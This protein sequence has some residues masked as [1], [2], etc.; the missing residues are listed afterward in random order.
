MLCLCLQYVLRIQSKNGA[1]VVHPMYVES[2]EGIESFL[3]MMRNIGGPRLLPRR[4]HYKKTASCKND[5]D[6]GELEEGG[7]ADDAG[8]K[9][10]ES[11]TV[12]SS[13]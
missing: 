11:E 9:K 2:E 1:F 10:E 7:D 5:D 8:G 12:V 6:E 3:C 4:R 13:P